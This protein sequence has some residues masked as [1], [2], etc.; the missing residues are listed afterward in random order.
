[1][2]H[3]RPAGPTRRI[4]ELAHR[5]QLGAPV[6]TYRRAAPSVPVA[7]YVF[8]ALLAPAT[9][10]LW[11]LQEWFA[12]LAATTL[13]ALLGEGAW[14]RRRVAAASTR[15][16][17]HQ[18]E[19][20]L[21]LVDGDILRELVAWAQIQR[22][23]VIEFDQ[24]GLTGRVRRGGL[25]VTRHRIRLACAGGR[26]IDLG[27]EFVGTEELVRELEARVWPELVERAVE[28]L[29]RGLTLDFGAVRINSRRIEV[30]GDA[31]PIANV[32]APPQR[33]VLERSIGWD[34]AE[35][36]DLTAGLTVR[37]HASEFALCE[38]P[39][40]MIVDFRLLNAVIER[41]QSN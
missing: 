3:S 40:Q 25:V 1:M 20:G 12:A 7:Q 31:A 11:L 32:L 8:V 36:V 26:Q 4:L 10:G 24:G 2:E 37:N 22:Y 23:E 39:R 28:D 34:E 16:A 13:V 18:F 30:F 38:V 19:Q 21:I 15:H 6:R 33:P 5:A 27:P 9:A 17:L 29:D 14:R 41:C 35:L